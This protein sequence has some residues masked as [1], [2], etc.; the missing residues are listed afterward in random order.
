M[1]N[2]GQIK[3]FQI[4]VDKSV[5][6]KYIILG[7]FNRLTYV[8]SNEERDKFKSIYNDIKENNFI[9][10]IVELIFLSDQKKENLK[11]FYQK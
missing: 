10:D 5:A 7:L 1:N 4:S 11:L 9:E 3:L 2:F 6:L 8:L